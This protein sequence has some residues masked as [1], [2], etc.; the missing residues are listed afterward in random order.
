MAVSLGLPV[1]IEWRRNRRR[2]WAGMLFVRVTI[3]GV[4]K[5]A[6]PAGADITEQY[7]RNIRDSARA[8]NLK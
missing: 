2:L 3:C 7:G 1:Q 4:S 5:F 8:D 6:V